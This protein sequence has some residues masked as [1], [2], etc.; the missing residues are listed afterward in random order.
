VKILF[1]LDGSEESRRALRYAERLH[2]TD[3]VTLI[4][5]LPTLLEAPRT[6]AYTDP[7][8]DP[9]QV[10]GELREARERLAQAGIHAETTTAAGNPAAEIL[11]AAEARGIELIVL[12]RQGQNAI[13]RFVMGSVADRVAP[14]H[15]RRLLVR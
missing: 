6:P 8:A 1:A 4:T 13:E 14:R 7:A 9:E 12:G 5:V 3:A 2:E 15:L 11:S 10:R